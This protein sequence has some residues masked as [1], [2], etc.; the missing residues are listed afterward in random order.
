[1]SFGTSIEMTDPAVIRALSHPARVRI[2]AYLDDG[3]ATATECSEA[4][5]QSPSAC[6]Y[7]L[8]TLAELGFV[9]EVASSDG[10]TRRWGLKVRGHGIPK[11]AQDSPEVQAAARLWGEQWAVVEHQL[12]AEYLGREPTE[13]PA[14]RK[15]ATFTSQEVYLT[16]DE[17]IGL[18]E[19]IMELF[20]PYLDR[21]DPDRRPDGA[22]P[23]HAALAAFPRLDPAE[24]REAKRRAARGR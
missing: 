22:R 8:R 4:V 5:G 1:M 12:L 9:E 19:R 10:R 17:L 11:R 23:V 15:A 21:A 6:S 20:E 2:M 14:W 7:H 24:R 13:S 16:P 18:G 3:P